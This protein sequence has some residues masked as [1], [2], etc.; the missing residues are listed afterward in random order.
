MYSFGPSQELRYF[1][2][3]Q[4]GTGDPDTG[5]WGTTMHG[6]L[7]PVTVPVVISR[8]KLATMHPEA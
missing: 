3:V 6:Y 5:S 2:H 1:R 8:W 4:Y 7:E